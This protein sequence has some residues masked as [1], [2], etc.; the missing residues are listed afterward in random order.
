MFAG[1]LEGGGAGSA[2]AKRLLSRSF[3]WAVYLLLFMS[4]TGLF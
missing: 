3:M 4:E 1:K 2:S